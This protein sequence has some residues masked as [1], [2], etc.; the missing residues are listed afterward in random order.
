[1]IN[2]SRTFIPSEMDDLGQCGGTTLNSYSL[3]WR[4]KAM[5]DKLS[6]AFVVQF[7][8]MEVR[9]NQNLSHI[10]NLGFT[11][12]IIPV[13]ANDFHFTLRNTI[14]HKEVGYKKKKKKKGTTHYPP[15]G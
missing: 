10:I 1:M 7:D 15:R 3:K 6:P 9:Y 8:I 5:R 11:V 12:N 14:G 2:A 13:S 4:I